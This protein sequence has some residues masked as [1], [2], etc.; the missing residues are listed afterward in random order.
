[1]VEEFSSL[2]R[3]QRQGYFAGFST[4]AKNYHLDFQQDVEKNA[5]DLVSKTTRTAAGFNSL[6]ITRVTTDAAAIA[7][8][9]H[10]AVLAYM[11]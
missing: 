8:T 4:A 10:M 3:R 11:I 9:L 2:L 6:R 5:Q 1:M 7:L